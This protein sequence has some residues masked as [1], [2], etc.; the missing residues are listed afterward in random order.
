MKKITLQLVGL[1]G[2]AFS[3][4]GAFRHQARREGW[5]SEEIEEV[6]KKAMSSDYDHLLQTIISHTKNP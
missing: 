5:S 1:D 6:S 2:N 4:V 3:I